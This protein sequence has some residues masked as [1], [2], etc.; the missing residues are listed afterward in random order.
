MSRGIFLEAKVPNDVTD[1]DCSRPAGARPRVSAWI[2][3]GSCPVAKE[4]G[5]R[6]SSCHRVHG[7]GCLLQGNNAK[8]GRFA[9]FCEYNG[10][11]KLYPFKSDDGFSHIGG[12][13]PA[14]GSLRGKSSGRRHV[15]P[16]KHPPGHCGV[17]GASV[18]CNL[19]LLKPFPSWSSYPDCNLHPAQFAA[20]LL[21]IKR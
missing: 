5:G 14:V 11:V 21:L 12:Y 7:K 1:R 18:H 4:V 10:S 9:F 17:R 19:Q 8:K 13:N 2:L 15:K 16:F 20:S 3:C 6:Q